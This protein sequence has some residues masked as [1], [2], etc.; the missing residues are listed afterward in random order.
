MKTKTKCKEK[1]WGES[2]WHSHQCTRNA[3]KDGF[4]KQHHPDIVAE[5]HRK[6]D[7]AYE[8]KRHNSLPERYYRLQNEHKKM[9]VLLETSLSFVMLKYG[10][11]LYKKD[12]KLDPKVDKF[13]LEAH[14][15]L[16]REPG[17]WKR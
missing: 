4:C 10:L 9:K 1:V 6:A 15:A 5:R 16:G 2:A 12:S 13:M 17:I 8:K 14:E 7:E 3:T 11:E